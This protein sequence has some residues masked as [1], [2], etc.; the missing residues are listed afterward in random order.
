M[1]SKSPTTH[2]SAELDEDAAKLLALGADPGPTFIVEDCKQCGGDGR[3]ITSRWEWEDTDLGPCLAC[4]GT[5][6]V[7]IWLTSIEMEDL[8][9]E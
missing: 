7:E 4:D 8:E 2:G 1:V 5:G 3:R 9:R 6:R